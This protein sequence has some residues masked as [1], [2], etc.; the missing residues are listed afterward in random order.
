MNLGVHHN[1]IIPSYFLS[2]YVSF[3][4]VKVQKPF[5]F[6][7][8]LKILSWIYIFFLTH[9]WTNMMRLYEKDRGSGSGAKICNYDIK[10]DGEDFT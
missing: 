8:S 7:G 6:R 4:V 10:G 5:V 2:V 3:L 1:Y 9:V